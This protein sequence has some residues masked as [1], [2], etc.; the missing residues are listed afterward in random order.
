RPKAWLCT[1]HRRHS[2]ELRGMRPIGFEPMTF[3]FVDRRSIRLSY[4]RIPAEAGRTGAAAP[5]EAEILAADDHRSP[6]AGVVGDLD[7]DVEG[8]G[9]RLGGEDGA[10]FG[11]RD[12]AGPPVQTPTAK[13]HAEER[14]SSLA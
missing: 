11:R 6:A 4:G 14:R 13:A 8:L 2:P 9:D 1:G 3:G 7:L 5:R 12:D 10:D